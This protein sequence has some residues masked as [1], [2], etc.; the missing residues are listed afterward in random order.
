MTMM[1]T[2]AWQCTGTMEMI[3][4]GSM[5]A[6]RR[7]DCWTLGNQGGAFLH[8]EGSHLHK[9]GSH[10]SKEGSH[11]LRYTTRRH[12]QLNQ[13]L[14]FALCSKQEP[15]KIWDDML[16]LWIAI[17]V[18][19][20]SQIVDWGSRPRMNRPGAAKSNERKRYAGCLMNQRPKPTS[21]KSE[22][23]SQAR[24]NKSNKRKTAS[25]FWSILYA[26][27]VCSERQVESKYDWIND[28][29]VQDPET[30]DRVS[31]IVT[32]FPWTFPI[33]TDDSCLLPT[34]GRGAA[35]NNFFEEWSQRRR[36]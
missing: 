15:S 20:K 28:S 24:A 19:L 33:P 16:H 25:S 6:P 21:D 9:E 32:V 11:W 34:R 13:V 5:Q 7:W 12:Q 36:F 23:V 17:L 26:L 10:L 14:D 30:W 29:R 3:L 35:A 31:W 2:I 4:L 8:K 18:F 22:Q 27:P 1:R